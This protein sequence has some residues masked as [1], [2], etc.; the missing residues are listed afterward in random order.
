MEPRGVK[1]R[2]EIVVTSDK[3]VYSLLY[4]ELIQ[5]VT[6]DVSA[7]KVADLKKELAARDLNVN[8]LKA[9]LATR[10]QEAIDTDS[11]PASSTTTG[12]QTESAKGEEEPASSTKQ[13]DA[14]ENHADS[15][16]RNEAREVESHNENV[17]K[18]S[19]A[20]AV[21][22]SAPEGTT[23]QLVGEIAASDHKAEAEPKE[24]EDA[25]QI[26]VEP[27]ETDI[28]DGET[29]LKDEVQENIE[30][31]QDPTDDTTQVQD[32]TQEKSQ[33]GGQMAVDDVEEEA[34]PQ[35]A[36]P[37]AKLD[38]PHPPSRAVKLLHLVRPILV[39]TLKEE[40]EKFGELEQDETYRN[41]IYL[42]GIKS[43]G[44]IVYKETSSAEAL[45]EK[46]NNKPFPAGDT[47]RPA[48]HFY[49]VPA[50]VVPKFI[51]REE[52]LWEKEQGRLQIIADVIPQGDGQP[53]KYNYY[54]RTLKKGVKKGPNGGG[55]SSSA[56]SAAGG[57][58]SSRGGRGKS[59]SSRGGGKFSNGF[60]ARPALPP[61][62]FPPIREP[63]PS[64]Y[65]NRSRYHPY[66]RQDTR[67]E[68]PPS[69]LP[70]LNRR[71]DDDINDFRSRPEA[72]APPP[73]VPS[74]SGYAK[75][76]DYPVNP[77]TGNLNGDSI[78]DRDPYPSRSR[79]DDYA[80]NR[81]PEPRRDYDRRRERDYDDYRERDDAR[82]RYPPASSDSRSRYDQPSRGHGSDD[83]YRHDRPRDHQY[84]RGY[85]RDRQRSP[86][87]YSRSR[88]DR[89]SR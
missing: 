19:S 26:G 16:P 7:L 67:Y 77:R 3:Y 46:Y 76:V 39:S 74:R 61:V 59:G 31:P 15:S 14:T 43:A 71:Y 1:S 85:E 33:T 17:D 81:H 6:M 66:A 63:Y 84:E 56:S 52:A 25:V 34:V 27:T 12:E 2:L 30:V 57:G 32:V 55:P 45:V 42:D 68:A 78:R 18:H 79:Y 69:N 38:T 51:Q 89:Y 23:Q 37:L 53:P 44:W 35:S 50:E 13:E 29:E 70:P 73:P 49:Y 41:G 5:K 28:G 80:Y 60:P 86:V 22:S 75:D 4:F 21:P 58:R 64:A 36:K 62:A 72:Q 83:R 9:E 82:G 87:S 8:G 48:V 65:D 20:L 40:A 24:E 11:K 88:D 54:S 10:L 47:F